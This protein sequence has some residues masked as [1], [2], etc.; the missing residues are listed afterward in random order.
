MYNTWSV[1]VHVFVGNSVAVGLGHADAA[2]TICTVSEMC[3]SHDKPRFKSRRLL[4]SESM[5]N[6]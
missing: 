2:V 6:R 5:D 1:C 4:L 3:Q